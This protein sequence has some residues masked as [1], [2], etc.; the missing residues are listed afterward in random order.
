MRKFLAAVL[1]LTVGFTAHAEI[2][3]QT[4][5]GLQFRSIGPALMSGRIAD[6]AID[7]HDNDIWYVAVGSGGVWK[8]TNAGTTWQSVFDGQGSYSIGAITLDPQNRHTVWVGT[9]E[10]V[11]GRHV[12]YGDG[13]YRSTDGGQSWENLGLKDSEHISKIIVHPQDSN[14]V[15]VAAQ[16]PLWSPGGERGVYKTTDGGKTWTASL[17]E[18]EWTGVTDILIDPREPDR[19]YAATWQR[20]RSVAAYM[21][22]GPNTAIYR[23]EDGGESWKKLSKGLPSGNKGKIG[24][25]ISPQQPDVVYAAIETNRREGGIYRSADR[26]ESWERRSDT[27]S[28]G[29]GPHY[30]QELYA[31]PHF[32]DHIYLMDV[33]TRVSTDGGSTFTTMNGNLKH[34]DHHAMAF[35]LDDPNYM[36]KGTDGGLYESFDGAAHW[37]FIDNLPVTQ[38]YKVAIDDAEPF[39]NVFGGTQ[40]NN[41]QG[42]PSRTDN[43]HGIRNADWFIT[44]F[45]DGHQPAT[46]PGN[47]DILYSEWQQGNLVRVDRITGELVYIRPQPEPEDPPERFNWDAP[48]LVSP[49]KPSRLYFASQRVWKSEDRG[50]S[51]TAISED[52]TLNQDRMLLPLMERQWSYEAP[53]DLYAMSTYNTIT[54]L[55]ESP[56][57]EGVL[58][59]GTDDG[60]ISISGDG[61]DNWRTIEVGDLPGVPDGAFVNDIK[62]DMH[63]ADTVY[64]VLDNH[65]FGDF[66]PYILK[67][68]N[69]GRSWD[70]IVEGIPDRTLVWRVVQDHVDPELMFVGTEFGVYVTVDG[71]ENWQKMQGGFPTISV[72]DLAIHKRENDLVAATFGRGFY[73]LDDYT[74]LRGFDEDSTEAEATLF[75]PR[76]AWWY[77]PR[78]VLSFDED[79]F[80]GDGYYVADNPPFGAV[81]TYFLKEAYQTDLQQQQERD[82]KR[83]EEGENAP[84]PGWETL[85]QQLAQPD[86]VLTLVVSDADGNVVRRVA[87]NNSAGF[88][89]VA[90]DLRH[91]SRQLVG[92]GGGFLSVQ[93]GLVMPG[94]Y[95]V[96]LYKTIDGETSQLSGPQSFMVEPLHKRSALKGADMETVVG[97]WNAVDAANG[98]LQLTMSKMR[99]AQERLQDIH[100]ALGSLPKAPEQLDQQH[101]ALEQQRIALLSKLQGNPARNAIGEDGV[102]TVSGRLFTAGLGTMQSTYGPTPTHERALEIANTQLQAIQKEVKQLIASDIPALEQQLREAGAPPLP[103]QDL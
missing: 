91:A 21:G 94:E 30:Y 62:A 97:F 4:F 8:T 52:L 23:S 73:I 49:H 95:S 77:F 22:G 63:D 16:G 7:Q 35:R 83:L 47:P 55:S 51:W 102:M 85:E 40:D 25:A 15:W 70:A 59:A 88:N 42:G 41:T 44:L 57:E 12:G 67:S 1:V 90:W 46:E 93:G 68:T 14:T 76:K 61:G 43:P 65:K 60:Q 75:K 28:G 66:Q 9:G 36:L 89:R 33:Q 39:Y 92:S 31:S 87:A 72:R 64:V 34:S 82:A 98:Q 5:A 10:N 86:P 19:L 101:Y 24:M 84:Y 17:N 100:T 18:H 3:D 50:D 58:Y 96:S 45:G 56:V 48:I 11:G 29:T 6:I 99:E 27:V 13:I 26:G 54:S 32:F 69:R 37:S 81:F 74:A 103:S 38:F 79:H 80:Q 20:H 78:P 53:W 71:G 2:D